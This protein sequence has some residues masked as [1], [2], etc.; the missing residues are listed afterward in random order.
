M[1]FMIPFAKNIR[2]QL[3]LI[4]ILCFATPIWAATV[5][6]FVTKVDSPTEF[7]IGSLRIIMNGKTHCETE[8]MQSFIALKEKT[9]DG[10]LAHHY[11][12]LQGYPVRKSA[13]TITCNNIQ[14]NIGSR[15]HI[16]GD[17]ASIDKG[18]S[19]AHV[20]AYLITIHPIIAAC[21][22]GNHKWEGGALLEEKP[23]IDQ[24]EHSWNVSMWL[25]GYPMKLLPDAEVF[26]EPSD[27][28]MSYRAF[29]LFESPRIGAVN[30][31]HGF[32][33][34]SANQWH[35][36]VWIE[37]KGLGW[38][39]GY[40]EVYRVRQWG[41][42]VDAKE[43]RYLRQFSPVIKLPD[44]QNH[45][46][47]VVKYSYKNKE[48]I[49]KILPDR[50]V[51]SFMA[52]VGMT[53]VPQYQRDLPD[54]AA[55]KIH[56]RFF[57]VQSNEV[58]LDNQM[59]RS[60]ALSVLLRPSWHEAV[61]ASPN[62]LII[63]PVD[64]LAKLD[65]AAQLAA[66]FSHVITSVLQK[67]GYMEKHSRPYSRSILC[68]EDTPDWGNY[69]FALEMNEQSMRIGIRQMYLAGYDIREAPFAWAVAQGK[70]VQNPIINSKHPDKEIPWYAAYA[71]N[72]IS[73]YYSD[74]DYSK[75]KRGEREYQQFLQELYKADP[76]LPRPQAQ[77]ESQ[78]S[79]RPRAA[80]Q[81]APQSSP[82]TPTASAPPAASPVAPSSATPAITQAH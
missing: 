60:D 38:Y 72:Y 42:Q 1:I 58:A 53:L 16:L 14:L 56:F 49:F 22:L 6:G 65:S 46:P 15:V 20:V 73:H 13:S 23:H 32:H 57:V 4:A 50:I 54:S 78:A 25:D 2:K 8:T 26:F 39:R 45:I 77:L 3:F 37:Y 5:D 59:R 29:G 21:N 55:T 61:V 74:V 82:A 35:P 28:Q 11:V 31:W 68:P 34:S 36:G 79:T 81:P 63:V 44:Y 17:I 64:M 76:S 71:F 40:M 47:G 51:Q 33:I 75:L 7:N 48:N 70:P 10:I 67:H 69:N 62:G 19:A 12:A 80:A 43:Q 41:N 27:T 9:F 30:I 24:I 18:F 52:R 66:I